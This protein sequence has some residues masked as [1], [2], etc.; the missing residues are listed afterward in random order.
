[1]KIKNTKWFTMVE[2]I[3]V[4]SI[5]AI[6]SAISFMSFMWY[7]QDTRDATRV[8]NVDLIHN[9]LETVK[10]TTWK[11]PRP[12]NAKEIT[13]AWK[14]LWTHWI[15]WEWVS[16]YINSSL[17]IDPKYKKKRKE[18]ELYFSYWVLNDNTDFQIWTILENEKK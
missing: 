17:F 16:N 7:S 2:L 8:N 15:V 4:I 3:V 9:S 14:V 12:D 10:A 1:M 11:Y 5:L 18:I 13:Y 6:L